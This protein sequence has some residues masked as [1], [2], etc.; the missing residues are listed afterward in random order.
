[1]HVYVYILVLQPRLTCCCTTSISRNTGIDDN[2]VYILKVCISRKPIQVSIHCLRLQ[3]VFG[4]HIQLSLFNTL[5]HVIVS[6]SLLPMQNECMSKFKSSC[7]YHF[8]NFQ[9]LL[10]LPF[11]TLY[12]IIH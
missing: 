5:L 1:M 11:H 7:V 2:I 8:S 3:Y 4:V 12:T 9:P 6:L 10:M